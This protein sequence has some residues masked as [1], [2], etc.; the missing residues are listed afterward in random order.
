MSAFSHVHSISFTDFRKTALIAYD[1]RDSII[2]QN[3]IWCESV[4]ITAPKQSMDKTNHSVNRNGLIITK[5]S[6]FSS[7]QEHAT[8]TS[9]MTSVQ[10]ISAS[11]VSLMKKIN[12]TSINLERAGSNSREIMMNPV[13]CLLNRIALLQMSILTVEIFP[14]MSA[15]IAITNVI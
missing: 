5:Y 7:L 4:W 10:K 9:V 3:P 14:Q 11:S 12:S 15:L 6:I 2:F 8:M 1:T 13:V